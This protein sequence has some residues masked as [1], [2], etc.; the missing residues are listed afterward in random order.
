MGAEV[1]V[2]R[3]SALKKLVRDEARELARRYQIGRPAGLS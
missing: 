2:N 3:P 1:E